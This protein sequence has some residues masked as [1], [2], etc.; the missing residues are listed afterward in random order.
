MVGDVNGWGVLD[1]AFLCCVPVE[2]R[3]GGEAT[4]DGGGSSAVFLEFAGVE[5]DVGA[6]DLEQCEVVLF[7]PAVE[8]A[9]VERVRLSGPT[10][11]AGQEPGDRSDLW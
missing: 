1:D 5:L 4:P 10:G 7:A 2:A 6:G 11:V 9:Q 8:H 3:Q